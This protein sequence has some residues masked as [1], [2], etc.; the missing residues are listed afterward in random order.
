M[1]KYLLLRLV[2]PLLG[3][4]HGLA[5]Q[6]AGLAGRVA[7]WHGPTRRRL[8]RTQA[9]LSAFDAVRTRKAT[10][11]AAA[12]LA[13][14]YVDLASLRYRN[15]AKFVGRELKIT[16]PDGM[17]AVET[18]GPRIILGGHIAGAELTLRVLPEL[19]H[20][21][22]ALVEP[23]QPAELRRYLVAARS[24]PG[25]RYFPS[26]RR[27]VKQCLKTLRNGGLV[28]LMG[29]RDLAG[30]GVC[31]EFFGRCVRIPRGPWEMAARTSAS[32]IPVLCRKRGGGI[33]VTIHE[34]ITVPA[35]KGKQAAIRQ[36]AQA[37]AHVLEQHLVREPGQWIVSEDFWRNHRCGE[38]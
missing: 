16:N 2:M 27:G 28:A 21:F 29:D 7:L 9:P 15:M 11:E 25:A 24:G 1:T 32:V 3:R 33:E 36:A 19:G 23:L 13:G 17:K 30:D 6:A 22:T 26:G 38:G 31:V 4:F 20:D 35:G 34:A 37:W 12:H 10:A 5:Y 18:P 14:Y 8:Y